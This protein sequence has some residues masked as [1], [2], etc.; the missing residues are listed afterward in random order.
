MRPLNCYLGV[1]FNS[2]NKTEIYLLWAHKQLVTRVH[3]TPRKLLKPYRTVGPVK[4]HLLLVLLKF[5]R[6]KQTKW[7]QD[8]EIFFGQKDHKRDWFYRSECLFIGKCPRT[9][10]FRGVWYIH[11]SVHILLK[12]NSFWS[13]LHYRP[14]GIYTSCVRRLTSGGSCWLLGESGSYGFSHMDFL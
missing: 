12:N 1:Y 2:G 14:W 9:G 4:P 7:Q 11:Y 3:Q 8:A 6:S 10:V 13:L 5:Y